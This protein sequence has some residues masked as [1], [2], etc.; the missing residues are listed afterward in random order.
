MATRKVWVIEE[1]ESDGALCH[2]QS[3]SSYEIDQDGKWSWNAPADR[4]STEAT[5][6][7]NRV[8]DLLKNVNGEDLRHVVCG[9]GLMS[10]CLDRSDI[11]CYVN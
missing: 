1:V 8:M 5:A 4:L 10:H 3:D 11:D 7:W 2:R 9:V 6:E